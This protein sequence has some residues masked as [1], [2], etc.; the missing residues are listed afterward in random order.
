MP[1]NSYPW[2]EKS[3]TCSN[4][5][6]KV[7]KA[8]SFLVVWKI[9]FRVYQHG[10]RYRCSPISSSWTLAYKS[11]IG[12]RW[13]AQRRNNF[14]GSLA[15]FEN[16]LRFSKPGSFNPNLFMKMP[17][18]FLSELSALLTTE[19]IN[20]WL[21]GRVFRSVSHALSSTFNP[22]FAYW[23][24]RTEKTHGTALPLKLEQ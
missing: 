2:L 9:L 24:T 18:K 12:K 22:R 4:Y 3:I 16:V 7:L 8:L 21:T 5:K 19:R 1:A 23:Q 6:R 15:F 14:C 20:S 13:Q 11:V 10:F 17:V